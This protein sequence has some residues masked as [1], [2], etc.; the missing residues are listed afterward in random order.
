LTRYRGFVAATAH[1]LPAEP[2]LIAHASAY[3]IE[4]GERCCRELLVTDGGCTAIAAANDML[5]VGCYAALELAG[6]SCPKDISV[7]RFSD[8]SFIDRLTPPLTSVSFAHYE[9][10]AEADWL[11]LEQIASG[12][13][14][15]SEAAAEAEATDGGLVRYLVPELKIRGSA[16]P[17]ARMELGK[18]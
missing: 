11:V 18:H 6:K 2:D 8:T 5:A 7:V 4:E 13:S 9:V 10:G 3:S 16:G 17:P 1:S 12:G 14:G 15:G